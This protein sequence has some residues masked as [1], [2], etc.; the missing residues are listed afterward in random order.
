MV[1][2]SWLLAAHLAVK[3][4]TQVALLTLALMLMLVAV[5]VVTLVLIMDWAV[6]VIP[7]A[8]SYLF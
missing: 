1:A 2:N 8:C 6:G 7:T 4:L 3:W 5:G